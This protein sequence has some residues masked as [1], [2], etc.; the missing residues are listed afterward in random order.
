ACLFTFGLIS[1]AA[2]YAWEM[3]VISAV[4]QIGLALPMA[5][6]FHRISFSGLSA[7]MII[8]PLMSLVVPFGFA[9]IF[10]GWSWLAR[11]AGFLLVASRQVAAWHV[12][13]EPNWR[14]PDPPLW[15]SIAFVAALIGL[16]F[17][18][19]RRWWRWPASAAVLVLFT[20]IF[21]HPFRT[22]SEV[23]ARHRRGCGFTL[24]LEPLDWPARRDRLHA[25]SR[26]SRRWA[27]G[28]D[29]QFPS[30]RTLGGREPGQRDLA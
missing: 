2:L 20:L 22:Q 18:L 13:W 4:I 25:C 28:V 12:R 16:S 7:N 5:I 8:V 14:I 9:A 11:I 3:F 30:H 19:S 21:W 6:Y 27:R 24:S 1:R 10:T 23:E 17:A 29:R 15:L 26:G